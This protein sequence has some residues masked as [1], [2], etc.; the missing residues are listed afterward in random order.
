MGRSFAVANNYDPYD[1]TDRWTI[2]RPGRVGWQ[3]VQRGADIYS[4]SESGEVAAHDN[5][6]I[7]ASK[8]REGLTQEIHSSIK[9]TSIRR[10]QFVI[11][12]W[13]PKAKRQAIHH[14]M[15]N[16]RTMY[17]LKDSA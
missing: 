4:A 8:E 3:Y 13:I 16:C 7:Q 17:I 2:I 14:G 15:R 6:Q 9:T 12:S 10:R 11:V 1:W 5:S